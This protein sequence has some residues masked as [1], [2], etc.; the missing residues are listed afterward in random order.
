[1]SVQLW[2]NL[3]MLDG[4]I[5]LLRA[6]EIGVR[7]W[8]AAERR[9]RHARNAPTIHRSLPKGLSI[10]SSLMSAAADVDPQVRGFFKAHGLRVEICMS[11]YLPMAPLHDA[12]CRPPWRTGWSEDASYHRW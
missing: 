4:C 11:S 8:E 12:S 7:P 1:M 2:P 9:H 3:A 5:V 10:Y 6:G